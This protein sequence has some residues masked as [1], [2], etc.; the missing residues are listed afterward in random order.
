MRWL[1]LSFTLEGLG[2]SVRTLFWFWV[3]LDFIILAFHAKSRPYR[4]KENQAFA[5]KEGH[6]LFGLGLFWALQFNRLCYFDFLLRVLSLSDCSLGSVDCLFL[7]CFSFKVWVLR[8]DFVHFARLFCSWVLH[9]VLRLLLFCK[10][11]VFARL[12]S[13]VRLTWLLY[14]PAVLRLHWPGERK[15]DG[16]IL[17]FWLGLIFDACLSCFLLTL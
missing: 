5:R 2:T 13:L 12:T 11:L 15:V 9:F 6:S 4:E 10:S 1:E 8:W 14:I 3:W 7:D 17:V 16:L